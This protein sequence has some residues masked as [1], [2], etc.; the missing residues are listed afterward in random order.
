MT[1]VVAMAAAANKLR[2][3]NKLYKTAPRGIVRGFDC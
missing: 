3:D 2:I 1:V